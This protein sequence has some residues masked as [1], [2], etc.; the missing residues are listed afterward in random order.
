V[1]ASLLPPSMAEAYLRMSFF[2][3][4]VLIVLLNAGV[5][6]VLLNPLFAAVNAL[7]F[8]ASAG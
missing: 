8:G 1:V 7:L 6:D 4:I 3:F 2:G 5:L